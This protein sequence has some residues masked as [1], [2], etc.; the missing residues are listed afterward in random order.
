VVR[1][2]TTIS[3]ITGT[4]LSVPGS[5]TTLTAASTFAGP[6]FKWY[7]AATGGNLLFTG[8]AYTTPFD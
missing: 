8:A 1:A 2:V 5:S 4:I 7:D 3:G 6:V